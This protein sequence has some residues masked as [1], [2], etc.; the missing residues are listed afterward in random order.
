MTLAVVWER[1]V[2]SHS[3]LLIASDSTVTGGM[4]WNCAPKI[5]TLS[6]SDAALCFAGDTLLAYPLMLQMRMAIDS[7]PAERSGA[8]D[9]HD[10]KRHALDLF[11]GMLKAITDLPIGDPGKPDVRFILAGY[12]WKSAGFGVY[13]IEYNASEKKLTARP[14]NVW[15]G[16]SPERRV[17]FIGDRVERAKTKFVELLRA[18]G[19]LQ[20]GKI[21]YEP[22]EVLRDMIRERQFR[23]IG[24][25]PQMVKIYRH[26]NCLPYA[27]YWPDKA[28]GKLCVMGRPLLDYEVTSFGVFDPNTFKV[29]HLYELTKGQRIGVEE[30]MAI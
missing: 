15:E 27:M 28:A 29:E 10:L 25:A 21:D 19:K 16:P 5:L 2:P 13:V 1:T 6:R 23:E 12:S 26:S 7:Y 3:E 11:N 17:A 8:V 18:K 22:F 30:D 4:V 14:V 20:G 24:G 9:F